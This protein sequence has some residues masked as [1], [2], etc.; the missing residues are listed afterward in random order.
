MESD[1]STLLLAAAHFV[2][3]RC[4]DGCPEA[5]RLKVA[6]A[7]TSDAATLLLLLLLL[8]YAALLCQPWTCF[9]GSYSNHLLDRKE[10]PRNQRQQPRPWLGA[11]AVLPLVA[12]NEPSTGI[13]SYWACL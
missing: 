12:K 2:N 8:L 5:S 7:T 10:D 9:N 4:R 11:S 1:G 3:L 13:S 6:A